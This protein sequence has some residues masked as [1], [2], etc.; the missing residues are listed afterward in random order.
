M[1]STVNVSITLYM[2]VKKLCMRVYNCTYGCIQQLVYE[3]NYG[4]LKT[5]AAD[6]RA[7]VLVKV[8]RGVGLVD[9]CIGVSVYLC[10]CVFVYLCIC[11]QG[12]D[13]WI[14]KHWEVARKEAW[15]ILGQL[16]SD[17]KSFERHRL[18]ISSFQNTLSEFT[19]EKIQTEKKHFRN[20]ILLT[21]L[22]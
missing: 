12:W 21:S 2:N 7:A 8:S 15:G 9:F 16:T 1:Y 6:K 14:D 5:T 4:Q 13:Q 11:V 22:E 10:I 19:S 17:Q 20:T 18:N 3:Y